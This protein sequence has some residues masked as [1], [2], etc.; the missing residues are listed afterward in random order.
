MGFVPPKKI[1][2]VARRNV[3]SFQLKP[4]GFEWRS[5]EGESV[6]ISGSCILSPLGKGAHSGANKKLC[7]LLG[8]LPIEDWWLIKCRVNIVRHRERGL[9]LKFYIAGDVARHVYFQLMT[10]ADRNGS[11]ILRTIQRDTFKSSQGQKPT[12]MG[13]Y[14][15]DNFARAFISTK[16]KSWHKGIFISR[17]ILR[18]K[19]RFL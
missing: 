1:S 3:K 9:E 5:T 7:G 6:G 16:G 14:L 11:F 4:R 10:K 12:E 18:I 8:G 15:A 17:A 19:K 13:V 2:E